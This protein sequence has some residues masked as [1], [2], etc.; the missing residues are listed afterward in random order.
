[1]RRGGPCG[2]GSRAQGVAAA[3]PPRA[4]WQDFRGLAGGG[5]YEAVAQRAMESLR[6]GRA[7]GSAEAR[8]APAT[9]EAPALAGALHSRL[10][11]VPMGAPDDAGADGQTQLAKVRV[12]HPLLVGAEVSDE[13]V[14]RREVSVGGGEGQAVQESA[15]EGLGLRR[16]DELLDARAP[17]RERR[18]CLAEQRLPQSA[19]VAVLK[20]V[21]DVENLDGER[22][23]LGRSFQLLGAP[24]P[25]Q[26][27]FA[28]SSACSAASAAATERPNS[29]L[30]PR[31]ATYRGHETWC[32][33]PTSRLGF[34]CATTATFASRHASSRVCNMLPSVAT[35][36]A[37]AG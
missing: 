23:E 14:E 5:R 15:D 11:H 33:V 31:T 20:A 12:L 26:A 35:T 10:E 16:L 22:T 27:T 17:K 6:T 25:S 37:F 24:S 34:R 8:H 28:T 32:G 1:L 30:P 9:G 7:V 3:Y 4:V 36:S 18:V 2:A 13:T 29:V 19:V 21:D